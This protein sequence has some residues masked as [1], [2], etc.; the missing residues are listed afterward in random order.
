MVEAALARGLDRLL[1]A[2]GMGRAA[3]AGVT[4][5]DVA[6][7]R[8]TAT[9]HYDPATRAALIARVRA[10][11][12]L[13]DGRGHE[14]T[15]AHLWWFDKLGDEGALPRE[16]SVLPY[17]RQVVEGAAGMATHW[18][19][20]SDHDLMASGLLA[21]ALYCG[22]PALGASV[23]V[24]LT[25]EMRGD[26]N[27]CEGATLG[28]R[29]DLKRHF[30]VSAALYAASTDTAAFGIGEFKELIDSGAGG[31][32]FSFDDMA[33]NLAGARFAAAFLDAPRADW[34]AKL[35]VLQGEAD[36]LPDVSDLPSR[37]SEPEF[38]DRF[39]TVDSPAYRAMVAEIERRVDALPLHL[40]PAG[41]GP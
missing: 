26:A 41:A 18:P 16:G 3:L 29:D 11:L 5:L 36:I 20:A 13:G 30:A 32:G 1:D 2:P 38:R 7:G 12:N 27:H 37:M 34:P 22:E 17:L 10:R 25:N 35:A 9:Y 40:A 23:G 33:A 14:P 24:R 21:L 8:V 31:T 15:Y 28:G 39:G 19:D 6:D 4:A